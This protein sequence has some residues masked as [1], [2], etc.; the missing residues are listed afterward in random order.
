MLR[1]SDKVRGSDAVSVMRGQKIEIHDGMKRKTTWQIHKF[2]DPTDEIAKLSRQGMSVEELIAMFPERF[3]GAVEFEGNVCLNEGIQAFEELLA[4]IATPTKWDN[5]NART[6]VGDSAT[7]ENAT[8]T[9]LQA[10]TNK[11]WRIMDASYPSRSGQ[12][13]SWRSTY[14]STEANYAWNEFTVVNAADDSG[15]NL[16]RKVSA[17]GTK[18]S[19]QT[20]VLTVTITWS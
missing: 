13:L 1:Q 5:T 10:A 16:N 3:L 7:G 20:W 2:D 8:Q 17:Q 4:G 15:L 18:T 14:G 19:G 6:G 11:F 9:G 12:A